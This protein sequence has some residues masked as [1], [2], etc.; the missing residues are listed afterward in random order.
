MVGPICSQYGQDAI[1]IIIKTMDDLLKITDETDLLIFDDMNF[2]PGTE[3]Q[4]GLNLTAEQII[5]L[6]T[7]H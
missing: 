7:I 6:L 5:A 1:S 4:P 2:G 3:E